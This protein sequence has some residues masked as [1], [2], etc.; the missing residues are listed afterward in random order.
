MKWFHIPG[1]PAGFFGKLC[2]QSCDCK[3]GHLCDPVT[4]Q[5][6]CPPGYLGEHCEKRKSSQLLHYQYESILDAS[7]E[8]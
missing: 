4:G 1:C 6:V 7:A 8:N 3:H 2:A 5:C